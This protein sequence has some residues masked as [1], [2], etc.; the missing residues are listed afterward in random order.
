MI[1]KDEYKYKK[2]QKI[3]LD[4]IY[5]IAGLFNGD[6]FSQIDPHD[7]KPFDRDEEEITITRDVH[8]IIIDKG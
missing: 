3:H 6:W 2:G 1:R 5:G 7:A 8:F 4:E